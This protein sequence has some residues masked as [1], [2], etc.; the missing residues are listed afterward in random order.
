MDRRFPAIPTKARNIGEMTV[1]LPPQHSTSDEF[2]QY[3][4]GD[5]CDFD[6][7]TEPISLQEFRE[8]YASKNRPVIM[9]ETA[10]L[11]WEAQHWL[12]EKRHGDDTPMLRAS[13]RFF[14]MKKLHQKLNKAMRHCPLAC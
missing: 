13:Q 9:P 11:D 12:R 1:P 3:D 5:H 8:R 10:I 4:I 6:K 14:R 2:K 7:L